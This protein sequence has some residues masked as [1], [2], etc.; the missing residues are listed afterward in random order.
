MRKRIALYLFIFCVIAGWR[1]YDL[2]PRIQYQS[3]EVQQGDTLWTIAGKSDIVKTQ[4]SD[5]RDVVDLI[6]ASND[7]NSVAV[8]EGEVLQIPYLRN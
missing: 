6:M 8:R 3:Y 2:N 5:I 4:S 1:V 7:M